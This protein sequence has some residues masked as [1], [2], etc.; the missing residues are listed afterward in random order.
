MKN[1]ELNTDKKKP[2]ITYTVKDKVILKFEQF[3]KKEKK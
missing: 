3:L 2:K 1:K